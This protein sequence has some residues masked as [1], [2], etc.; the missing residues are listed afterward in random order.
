MLVL[1]VQ[2]STLMLSSK[3]T[4]PSDRPVARDFE[5]QGFI[6]TGVPT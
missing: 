3:G 6:K 5:D 2:T 1:V 4:T